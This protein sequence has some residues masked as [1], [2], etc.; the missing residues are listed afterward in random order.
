MEFHNHMDQISSSKIR[1]IGEKAAQMAAQGRSIIKLQAGEPDFDTPQHIVDA[2]VAALQ[3]KDTHYTPNRGTMALRQ[4]IADK[5]SRD[6]QINADPLENIIVTTGCAEALMCACL[7]ILDPEDEM[8]IIEPAFVTYMELAK[9]AGAV[10]VIVHAREDNSWLPDVEDIRQ[11]ITS[12]TKLLLINSPSNPTGAVYP[13]EL[14]Q[15]LAMLSVKHNFYI[16]SDEVYEKLAFGAEH[17]SIASLP[18]MADRTITVNGFSK[19]Y[20]MTGWRMGYLAASKEL[21]APMLKLHQ[22]TT[23]C[24]PGFIQAACVRA[25]EHSVEVLSMRQ[26]Y[27]RRRDLLCSLLECSSKLSFTKPE[28]TF[29]LYVNIERCGLD[30]ESFV[31]RLLEEKGVAVVFGTAFDHRQGSRNIRISFASSEENLREGARRLLEFIDSL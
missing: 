22:Y 10:P 13:R 14:L 3:N 20:A 16:V 19:A 8:I 5:L 15:E 6:N 29:Y 24:A 18:G 30:S 23:T 9:L 25:L 17:V 2:A 21:I 4:A 28:G 27:Q 11:A 31:M 26:A 1:M 12:R 7:G